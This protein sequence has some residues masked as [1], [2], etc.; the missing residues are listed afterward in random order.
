[1]GRGQWTRD[2]ARES[3]ERTLEG[4]Q[5]HGLGVWLAEDRATEEPV[6]RVGLSYHRAWPDEPELPQ[7]TQN[8]PGLP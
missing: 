3:I 8:C 2:E 6:G 5:R 4:Y 1:M 7:V